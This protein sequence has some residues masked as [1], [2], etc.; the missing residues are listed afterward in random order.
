MKSQSRYAKRYAGKTP[1]KRQLRIN[2]SIRDVLSTAITQG[3]H[4]QFENLSVTITDVR[5]S[6]DLK[7][8]MIFI[9]PL[10]GQNK[11]EAL[12]ILNALAPQLRTELARK[13]N[14]RYTPKLRFELDL[15]FESADI[16]FDILQSPQ[17]KQDI[18][19]DHD[20]D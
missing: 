9:M 10:G 17:V 18:D 19:P 20:K 15:S 5:V 13:I 7:S 12:E 8:A 2:E 4:I 16:I 14:L 6:V 3:G 1:K 11:D